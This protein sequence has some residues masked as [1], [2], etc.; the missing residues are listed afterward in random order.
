VNDKD[1]VVEVAP[2]V[3]DYLDRSVELGWQRY[4]KALTVDSG[5]DSLVDAFEE[6]VD[7]VFYLAQVLL[8]RDGKL[9]ERGPET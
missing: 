8:K 3:H 1:K 4:G 5:R 6:A 7:L 9:P 2:H